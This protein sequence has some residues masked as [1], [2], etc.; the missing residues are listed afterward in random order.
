[1]S[2]LQS[3]ANHHPGAD[4]AQ[5]FAAVL[6]LLV[7]LLLVLLSLKLDLLICLELFPRELHLV[8]VDLL[9]NQLILRLELLLNLL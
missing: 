9:A 6:N 5:E 3:V 7:D 2:C 8:I 4:G 1:M